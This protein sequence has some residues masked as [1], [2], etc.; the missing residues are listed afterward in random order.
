M[1][2]QIYMTKYG[3]IRLRS[4]K[5]WMDHFDGLVQKRRNSIAN[6]LE[7]CLSCIKLLICTTNHGPV[8]FVNVLVLQDSPSKYIMRDFEEKEHAIYTSA[9]C[10]TLS[11]Q[12]LVPYAGW[13][14]GQNC[15]FSSPKTW[16]AKAISRHSAWWRHQM[17]TFS[18]LL[19][20]C[21]GNS[22]VPVNSPH[23]GQWRGALMFTLICARINGWVNNCEAGDLRRNRA[24][25]D[26][27]V[28]VG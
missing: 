7:L 14:F 25:Y 8:W 19:A 12:V 27:I 6:A 2:I 28:M 13:K 4:V 15:A 23:K 16:R 10:P 17:K 26:V 3:I 21:A 20:I 5:V 24:H 9:H 18:A 1:L 22:P 11:F